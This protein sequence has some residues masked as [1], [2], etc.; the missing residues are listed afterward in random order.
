VSL[1]GVSPVASL[2]VSC[3]AGVSFAVCEPARYRIRSSLNECKLYEGKEGGK[4]PSL[5]NTV[6]TR[7]YVFFRQQEKIRKIESY[8]KSNLAYFAIYWIHRSSF[9][10]FTSISDANKQDVDQLYHFFDFRACCRRELAGEKLAGLERNSPCS[11]LDVEE[12]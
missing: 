4:V 7:F 3:A 2:S 1:A 8:V 6:E 5:K 9:F 11:P 10:Y 12:A